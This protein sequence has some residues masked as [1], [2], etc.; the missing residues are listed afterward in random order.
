MLF[1][2]PYIADWSKI[3]EYRQKQTDK[4]TRRKTPPA[5]TGTTSPVTK[6]CCEKT[7]SSA[8]QKAGMKVI[9][10]PSRQFIRMAP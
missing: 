1:D 7:V 9:L 4:N 2:V 3:G 5:L 8:K 6:Y 10:G